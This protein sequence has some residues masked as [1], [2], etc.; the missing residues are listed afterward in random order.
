MDHIMNEK[1]NPPYVD[2]FSMQSLISKS[3]YVLVIDIHHHPI[4]K[5]TI[6]HYC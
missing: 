1:K 3:S 2:L 5:L 4:R 6:Q